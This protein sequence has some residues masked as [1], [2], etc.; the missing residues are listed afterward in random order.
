MSGNVT[1]ISRPK[2]EQFRMTCQC[3]EPYGFAQ[4]HVLIGSDASI[5]YEC[6]NCGAEHELT[7]EEIAKMQ[8]DSW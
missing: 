1:S 3:A 7:P 2:I 5:A 6:V 4:F 8:G